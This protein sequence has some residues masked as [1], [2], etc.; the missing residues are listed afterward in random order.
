[1]R[2]IKFNF[3]KLLKGLVFIFGCTLLISQ[4]YMTVTKFNSY[5]SE[6]DAVYTI[7]DSV[8]NN[9][10]DLKLKLTGISADQRVL[11]LCNG[12]PVA[13]FN[14]SEIS[15]TVNNNSV[16]EIDGRCILKPFKV[17]IV[18]ED[19]SACNNILKAV[20]VRSNI[21]MLGRLIME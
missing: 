11:V 12:E 2:I 17:E 18:N 4:L 20:D 6:F 5:F 3:D 16:I 15:V 9:S 8:A 21:A 7:S 14:D 10:F 1:M 13:R 19:I